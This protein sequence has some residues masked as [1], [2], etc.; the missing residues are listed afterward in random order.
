MKKMKKTGMFLAVLLLA[1]GAF[2]MAGSKAELPEERE[3]QE[4]SKKAGLETYTGGETQAEYRHLEKTE[5]RAEG[6]YLKPWVL[7]SNVLKQ[8]GL[9]VT[10]EQNGV[11]MKLTAFRQGGNIGPGAVLEEEYK[12]TLAVIEKMKNVKNAKVRDIVEGEDY[13]LQEINYSLFDK[14]G[15]LF[16]C[17]VYIKIDELS[18]GIYLMNAITVDNS[19]GNKDTEETLKEVLDAYGIQVRQA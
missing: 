5:L 16:P 9:E 17:A 10:A 6:I 3:K 14:D 2:L 7:K 18:D 1:S 11:T 8:A 12:R 4:D 15:N 19:K 13:L